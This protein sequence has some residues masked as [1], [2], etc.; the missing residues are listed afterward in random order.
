MTGGPSG[1]R[2]VLTPDRV[3]ANDKVKALLGW[4]PRNSTFREGYA[5]LLSH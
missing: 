4:R 1:E 5:N 2:R 3:I